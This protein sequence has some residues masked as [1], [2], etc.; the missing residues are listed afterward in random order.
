MQVWLKQHEEDFT[1]FRAS[2]NEMYVAKTQAVKG[3]ITSLKLTASW[4][5]KMDGW[6][7]FSVSFWGFCLFS[8]GKLAVSF[9][10]GRCNFSLGLKLDREVVFSTVFIFLCW[11]SI[12]LKGLFQKTSRK[13][14]L[15]TANTLKKMLL[16]WETQMQF[17]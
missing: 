5:L 13:K 7:T 3:W 15:F 10:K 8:R 16:R 14:H 9:R 12:E 17:E 6:N 2:D 4:H 1:L 11:I